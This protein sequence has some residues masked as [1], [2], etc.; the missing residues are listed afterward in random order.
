MPDMTITSRR[1]PLVSRC[2]DAADGSA[3][4][5][6]LEGPHLVA[7]ALDARTPLSVIVVAEGADARGEIAAIVMRAIGQDLPVQYVTPAVLDAASPTR[8]PTGV[9]ALASL[10]TRRLDDLLLPAP[11]LVTVSM[12]I[13]DPGNVGTLLRSSEAA[14]ATGFL[15]LPGTAHPFGWKALRG[16]MG[17]ALRL[18]IARE[19]D[20][21]A[22]LQD[23]RSRG[24]RLVAL[25]AAADVM[26]D[27]AD[28]TGPIAI[29]AGA[30]GAGVPSEFLALAD[31]RLRI[32]MCAPVESLNVGVATSLV[33]FE[34]ARQR[35]AALAGNRQPAAGDQADA[36]GHERRSS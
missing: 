30:E 36:P 28:L 3:D 25:T 7:E 14:G 17:S 33:L 29:C 2:R 1:H 19:A 4:E 18:P 12:G 6:L 24:L 22:A 16:S 20:G 26:L 8:S 34:V 35:R 32:P 27:D 23:L 10:A 9:L 13:Q 21:T 15:A 11:P 5:V 31:V